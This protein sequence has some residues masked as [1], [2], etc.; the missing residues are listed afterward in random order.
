MITNLGVLTRRVSTVIYGE[1]TVKRVTQLRVPSRRSVASH[2][3]HIS[4]YQAAPRTRIQDQLYEDFCEDYEID[5]GYDMPPKS[6]KRQAEKYKNDDGSVEDAAPLSKRSRVEIGKKAVD[7][8]GN[9]YWEI[10]GRLR[11]VGV[12]KFGG[13][14]LINIR[15]YF[16]KD[17][18]VLPGKKGISLSIEQFDAFLSVLPQIEQHLVDL[19]VVVQRPN[20][21]GS[22]AV[23]QEDEGGAKEEEKQEEEE[24]I[25]EP[26]PKESSKRG[27]K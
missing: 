9:P 20:F 11:R 12:S 21:G 19:G 6:K 15:E 24:E 14:N 1:V 17:G 26:K 10:G 13:K 22:A 27:R 3:I 2:Q 4:S 23:E 8:E 7:N 5:Q 16:E 25:E 18:K